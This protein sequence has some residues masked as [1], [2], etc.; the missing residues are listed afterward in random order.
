MYRSALYL[1]LGAPSDPSAVQINAGLVNVFI[2]TTVEEQTLGP[3][4]ASSLLESEAV[5]LYKLSRCPW[6]TNREI[7]RDGVRLVPDS[8]LPT[9]FV[10]V[11]NRHTQPRYSISLIAYRMFSID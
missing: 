9:F 2:Y 7:P 4:T 1:L 5:D 8:L 3:S 10:V 11:C 6:M